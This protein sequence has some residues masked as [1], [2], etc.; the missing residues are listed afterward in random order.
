[1]VGP[2][3]DPL[4]SYDAAAGADPFVLSEQQQ[5]QQRQHGHGHSYTVPASASTADA[6]AV[7]SFAMGPPPH[8]FAPVVTSGEAPPLDMTM[9]SVPVDLMDVNLMTGPMPGWSDP[10]ADTEAALRQALKERDEARM[11]LST[12]KNEVYAARQLEKR[13]RAE[14]DEARSQVTFL[15]KERATGRLT[16]VRLRKER[17][18]ARMALALRKGGVKRVEDGSLAGGLGVLVSPTGGAF[19][20]PDIGQDEAGG[21]EG[22]PVERSPMTESLGSD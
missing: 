2:Y 16:E 17:N 18:Q 20:W 15:K 12:M 4:F 19:E 22:S 6:V 5:Q 1:M 10:S 8:A 21:K 11:A 14:R 9:A 13:L 7:H 3:A